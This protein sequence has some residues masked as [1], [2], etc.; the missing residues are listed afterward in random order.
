MCGKTVIIYCEKYLQWVYTNC[1]WSTVFSVYW[2]EKTS[3][4]RNNKLSCLKDF[5][6]ALYHLKKEKKKKRYILPSQNSPG[7]VHLRAGRREEEG[8]GNP[9]QYSCLENPMDGGAWWATVHGV[10]KE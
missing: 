2:G 1:C 7:A 8:N 4:R 5:P 9:L 10:T 3:Q 6:L